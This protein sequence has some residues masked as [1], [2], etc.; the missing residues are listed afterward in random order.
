MRVIALTRRNAARR[1]APPALACLA[2]AVA[3]CGNSA[4]A[5]T[6]GGTQ[7]PGTVKVAYPPPLSYL[8]ASTIGPAFVKTSGQRYLGITGPPD[9]LPGEIASGKISPNVLESVTDAGVRP[10]LPRYTR[11]W[12]EYA[13]TSLVL[14]Y[15]PTSKFASQ[16][17]AIAHGSEPIRDLFTVLEK[18]GFRLGRSDP[19]TDPQG[20]DLIY[21]LELAQTKYGLPPGAVQKILRGPLASARSP[22][23]STGAAVLAK[24]QSGR[25]DAAALYQAQ[26]I[27]LR[28]PYITLPAEI[29]LG[30]PSLAQHYSTAKITLADHV[31]AHGMPLVL[32]ITTLGTTDQPAADAFVKFVLS[33]GGLV[34]HKQLGYT[35]LTPTAFGDKSAIPKSIRNELAAAS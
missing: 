25:I 28:E 3:G 30:I 8:N 16:L 2:L 4:T 11:W 1:I 29:D 22:Q 13:A 20:R 10:L 33:P 34:L 6:S 18:P 26:A 24:L 17:T 35:L 27:E 14:A 19:N 23:I 9:A 32:D 15:S 21:L 31:V 12:I 5:A 7:P